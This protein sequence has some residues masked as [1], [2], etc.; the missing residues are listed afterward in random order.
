MAGASMGAYRRRADPS[1]LTAVASASAG[2]ACAHGDLSGTRTRARCWAHSFARVFATVF[3]AVDRRRIARVRGQHA[4][5]DVLH[6]RLA[7]AGKALRV[8]GTKLVVARHA[9]RQRAEARRRDLGEAEA[10]AADE[11]RGT[12][13]AEATGMDAPIVE[14]GRAR[15][16]RGSVAGRRRPRIG[17][18]I[19]SRAAPR[20]GRVR[21][22]ARRG[23][24]GRVRAGRRGG[25]I[26][27]SS[28]GARVQL[29]AARDR[30]EEQ[31]RHVRRATTRYRHGPDVQAAV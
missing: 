3:A 11:A 4:E 10:T 9:R 27:G 31:E 29:F 25:S 19:A 26:I 2:T 8:G 16:R 24:S 17:A 30:G 12:V 1:R 20:G 15:R 22:G 18:V 13:P 14:I 5:P 28:I 23:A 6:D 7:A 21:R